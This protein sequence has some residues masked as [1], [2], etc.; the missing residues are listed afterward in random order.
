MAKL[1]RQQR[2]GLLLT[3]ILMT[4]V[5]LFFAI[6]RTPPAVDAQ[7]LTMPAVEQP[8]KPRA[9]KKKKPAPQPAPAPR[10]HLDEDF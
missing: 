6:I 10:K 4:L 5:A 3:G 1:T 9:A 8:S 2:L 7:D